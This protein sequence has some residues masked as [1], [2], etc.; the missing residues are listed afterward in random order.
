MIDVTERHVVKRGTTLTIEGKYF[1]DGCQDVGSCSVGGACEDQSCDYGPEPR[2]MTDVTLRLVQD[3]RR[4]N[5]G[6]TDAGAGGEGDG[7]VS[8]TFDVPAAAKR[9]PAKLVADQT[10]AVPVRIR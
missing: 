3:G 6:T 4:W 8:W 2:P 7:S 10:P 1:V 9:G 5:L